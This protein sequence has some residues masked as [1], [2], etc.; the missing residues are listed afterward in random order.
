[1]GLLE[2]LNFCFD[3]VSDRVIAQDDEST[4]IALCGTE[5]TGDFGSESG[6]GVRQVGETLGNYIRK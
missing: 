2:I 3:F 1:M 5:T 4:H 6:F